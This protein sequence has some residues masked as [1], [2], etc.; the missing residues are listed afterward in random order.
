MNAIQKAAIKYLDLGYRIC[1]Y[2]R[3]GFGESKKSPYPST[4]A[5]IPSMF[6]ETNIG[7]DTD[8]KLVIVDCDTEDAR[9]WSEENL[10]PTLWKI[11]TG[12]GVHLGYRKGVRATRRINVCG[13]HIDILCHGVRV[14]MPPSIHANGKE[15]QRLNFNH[16]IPPLATL[17]I[18]EDGWFPKLEESLEKR[19]SDDNV[20]C[21]IIDEGVSG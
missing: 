21:S 15:Y 16:D 5:W 12:R 7:I 20:S 9:K 10:P 18:F 19:A 17:P 11:E 4:T 2:P 3:V 6:L 8:N 13:M 14:I 1:E